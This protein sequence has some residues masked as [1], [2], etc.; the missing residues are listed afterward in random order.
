MG[1]SFLTT[2]RHT[3]Q[4]A[5]MALALLWGASVV[6]QAE[7]GLASTTLKSTEGVV[8]AVDKRGIAVEHETQQGGAAEMYLPFDP[9]LRLQGL[10][11]LGD[12]Q[13]GD[14]ARVDYRETTEQTGNES[15][16]SRVAT[17]VLLVRRAVVEAAPPAEAEAAEQ[18]EPTVPGKAGAP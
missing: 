11:A 13:A 10:K 15:K 7:T 1:S 3:A 17:R 14:T 12:L 18:P 4:I 5:G 6:V 8:T 16:T 2:M 9:A